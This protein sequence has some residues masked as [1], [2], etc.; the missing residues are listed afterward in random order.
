MCERR[1]AVAAAGPGLLRFLC[2]F[3]C[4]DTRFF[5]LFDDLDTVT[6]TGIRRQKHDKLLTNLLREIVE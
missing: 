6:H 2:F 1:R 4:G 5:D 3:S